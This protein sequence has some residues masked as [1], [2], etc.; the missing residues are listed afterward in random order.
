MEDT[1]VNS[2]YK[3]IKI[4]GLYNN[5]EPGIYMDFLFYEILTNLGIPIKIN[6]GYR[7]KDSKFMICLVSEVSGKLYD[8]FDYDETISSYNTYDKP[9]GKVFVPRTVGMDEFISINV[10]RG[11]LKDYFE[12]PYYIWNDY[13]SHIRMLRDKLLSKYLNKDPLIQKIKIEIIDKFVEHNTTGACLVASCL[14]QD[15][16]KLNNI[17][18]K[19]VKGYLGFPAEK[20]YIDHIWLEINGVC[21]DIGSEI[22]M[23]IYDFKFDCNYSELPF[24]NYSIANLDNDEEKESTKELLDSYKSFMINPSEFWKYAPRWIKRFRTNLRKKYSPQ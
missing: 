24:E 23:K 7:V 14:M 11:I 2:I 3:H 4:C 13:E 19:L 20:T 6:V 17:P 8:F 9:K 22:T 16:C 12:N 18:C 5:L 15:I 21:H 10:L 1:Q